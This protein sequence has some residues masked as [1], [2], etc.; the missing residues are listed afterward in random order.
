MGINVLSL[1]DG[2]SAGRVAL[3]RAGIEIDNYYA[4]EVDRYAMQISNKNYPD[5]KQMGDVTKWREWDI[6]WSSVELVSGGFP[7]QTWSV[8]G[9]QS[10]DKDA[11]G[12][13]FWV[14][15]DIIKTVLEHNPQAKFLM[16]N[17]RMKK[18]FEDY[19]TFHTE[20]AL[21]VVYKHLI[22]SSSVSAQSRK[23][24]Y[25]T[26]IQNIEQPEDKGVVL[27]DILED[28]VDDKYYLSSE[29]ID[30]MGRLRNGKQRWEFHKNP[31]DGKAA[32]L[33]ANM[34]KG[35]PY[36][37]V[38]DLNR[39]LTPLECERL[40]TFDDNYTEGISNSQRYKALGNSWT[41]D[42]IAHIFSYYQQ[43]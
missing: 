5:I 1:F 21:G 24:F 7:C 39:K 22:N 19:I 28:N 34:Y 41:V 35:V 11:R 4:S 3:E 26:N 32:C 9:S 42:V 13:L 15:L 25:W 16:E 36:G 6:D 8:A 31:V 10:G 23:R 14:M 33:T 29:A 17:V 20:Q 43:K 40:Q 2:I 37:V 18:E 12:Q 38:K 27:S 30:Y